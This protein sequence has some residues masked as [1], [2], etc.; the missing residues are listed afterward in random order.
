M[1]ST[2]TFYELLK[3]KSS[4]SADEV[5]Q[6]FHRF[7]REAHPDNFVTASTEELQKMAEHYRKV[8]EAYRVLRDS[9]T[10]RAYDDSLRGGAGAAA[11]DSPRNSTLSS[12]LKRP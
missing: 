11:G 4:A 1:A 8:T 2:P 10:R 9:S 3:I 12:G 6:A 7:A 5:R